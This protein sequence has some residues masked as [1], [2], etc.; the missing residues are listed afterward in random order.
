M[1]GGDGIKSVRG[2]EGERE[3]G[4]TER[5]EALRIREQGWGVGGGLV[6]RGIRRTT[7]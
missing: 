7:L 1:R 6:P 2:R 4:A 3:T 5:R